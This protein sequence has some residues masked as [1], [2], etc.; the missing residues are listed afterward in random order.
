M[1]HT[2]T[3]QRGFAVMGVMIAL[4]ALIA[5]VYGVDKM[6]IS[7]AENC[8]GLSVSECAPHVFDSNTDTGATPE[9][10]VTATGTV[11]GTVE[12]TEHSVTFSFI[13]PLD[14]GDVTGTFSGDCE[15][16]IV[17]TFAGGD[18]GTITGTAGGS[19]ASVIPVSGT[20]SGTVDETS[21]TVS[22]TGTGTVS[23]VVKSGS[24]QLTY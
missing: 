12:G 22:L 7:Y 18:G 15:G 23:G 14:G 20:Y 9:N 3:V 17:G 1:T 24:L 19:C 8:Q 13:I 5:A 16:K 10:S 21:R 4:F 2:P 11:S 6:A